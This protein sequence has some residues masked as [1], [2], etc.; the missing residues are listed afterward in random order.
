MLR[1]LSELL[2]TLPT[3]GQWTLGAALVLY[4]IAAV[5]GRINLAVGAKVFSK[6]PADRIRTD[7][8]HII[9]Y[10]VIPL[11]ATTVYVLL[12]LTKHIGTG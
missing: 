10:T 6:I 8:G 1:I 9:Q 5:Y 4:S 12:L 7:K 3:W 2:D 11:V